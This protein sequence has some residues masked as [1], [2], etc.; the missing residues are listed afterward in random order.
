MRRVAGRV[1]SDDIRSAGL[2]RWDGRLR[3][4]TDWI[5]LF[6]EPELCWPTGDCLVYL[7]EPGQ[8]SRGPAFRVH[9]GFLRVKGFESLVERC[10]VRNSIH[11]ASECVLPNCPGCDPEQSLLELYIPAPYGAGLE[12]IF[13]HHITTRNFFAWLYNRPLA[14]RTLGKALVELKRR[15]DVYRPDDSSQNKLEVVSYAESQRYL[16][17]RECVDHALA[18]LHLA[19]N[20][21][22]EDLWVDA[23]S[24]CV[25]MSHRGL[26]SSIEY[27]MVSSRSKSLVSRARTEMD[28]RLQNVDKALV[29]FFEEEVSNSFLRLPQ[30]AKDHLDR[31]RV[32]LKGVY[33]ERYGSW[34]P[35]D[36]EEESV[37]QAVYTAIFGDFQNLYQHLVDPNSVTGM[38][39]TDISK[40]GGVCTIQN[41]QAFDA[42]H[43]FEPLAQPLPLIP[44]TLESDPGPHHSKSVRRKSWNPILK[45]KI[46]REARK[47]RDKQA[48]TNASNRDVLVMECEVVKKFSQFEQQT[49][50]DDLVGLPIAEGRKVRW[51]LVY[52]ILQV[53]HAVM[54]APKQ[55][56]NSRGLTYSICCHPPKKL[57]WQESRRPMLPSTTESL[58]QL[59]LVPDQ[60][61]SHTNVTAS[62]SP[63]TEEAPRGRSFMA[64]RRTLPAHL[65]GALTASLMTKS[66]PSSRSS[67]LRRL[68]S[69]CSRA[70][71]EPMPAKRSAFCQI[72]VEGYGNGL[73]EVDS[74]TTAARQSTPA[75]LTAEPTAE[76][77][78]TSPDLIKEEMPEP[79]ELVGH[80]VHELNAVGVES[81]TAPEA[82]LLAPVPVP[83]PE[84]ESS[85]TPPQMSR[86]SSSASTSSTWSKKSRGSGS[87]SDGLDPRTP[88]DDTVCTLQEILQSTQTQTQT[89]TPKP[90]VP[91]CRPPIGK[92]TS[93]CARGSSHTIAVVDHHDS[94]NEN[95]N[96]AGTGIGKSTYAKDALNDAMSV[97]SIHFNTLTWDRILDQRCVGKR[98]VTAPATSSIQVRA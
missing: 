78:V 72:Y 61:Y 31:A 88:A 21:E 86:E 82:P 5:N 68:M 91:S 64:R 57:P 67:S 15:I 16:D 20:L 7:R 22:I 34:P 47:A 23:F 63:V 28:T 96:R 56:R 32:F 36:F 38:E 18:A 39:E 85:S 76:L 46:D 13:D 70:A 60:S 97:P 75:E 35:S 52:A 27:A 93:S 30:T 81:V 19:E 11:A 45:R 4:T 89:H 87:D 9:I 2:R 95:G 66:A 54:Q 73:N 55:V 12:E 25:G 79:H 14:G 65:P 49:V 42:K 29:D 92:R 26:R 10:V 94:D 44:V 69:R 84:D 37:K 90:K 83:V 80:E 1:T 51:M 59:E 40:T 98:P 43:G 24:H 77:E 33:V 8:S 48:L 3:V 58:S 53:L 41:I 17:F 71:P 6:H 74:N 62:S 50:D